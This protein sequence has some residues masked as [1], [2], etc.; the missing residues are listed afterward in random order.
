M[1][2]L[3][4]LWVYNRKSGPKQLRA[5]V[6]GIEVRLVVGLVGVGGEW[7]W[8]ESRIG[9]LTSEGEGLQ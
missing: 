5:I 6:M 1:R 7:F 8:G 2:G 4:W 9:G 3:R